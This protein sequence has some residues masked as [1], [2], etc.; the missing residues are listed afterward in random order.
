MAIS[1]GAPTRTAAPMAVGSNAND[2]GFNQ[3]SATLAEIVAQATGQKVLAPIN[4]SEFVSVATTALKTGYDPILGAIS[5]VISRTLFS[6]RPY[7]SKFRGLQA[8][9]IRY[10]NHVRKLSPVQNAPRDDDSMKPCGEGNYDQ[11][12]GCCPGVLQ[13]NFYGVNSYSRCLKIFR[14]Q[15]NSA[16]SGPDEFARFISMLM[17]NVSSM[18]EL[19][20]EATSRYV[21]ANL[22][23]GKIAGDTKNVRHLITE[24][25][26]LMGTN[27]T[28]DTIFA[29]EVFQNFARWLYATINTISGKLS[30]ETLEYHINVTGKPVL[31]HTPKQMQKIY[32]NAAFLNLVDTMVHTVNFDNSFMKLSDYETVD[33]WQSIGSDRS[34]NITPTYMLSDGSLTT[35]DVA[36]VNN[37]V[38]GV[39]FDEEAAGYTVVNEW[40]APTPFNARG[41]F[42]VMWWHYSHRYWNDFTENAVVL[43]LD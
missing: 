43:L 19:D 41:G 31:R 9:S 29:P 24:Y 7:Y 11:Y 3:L 16:F 2:M 5:Q 26:T 34:I 10:G 12:E 22:I 15:L 21:V 42:S 8:D 27:Y 28:S 37:N 25:N 32:L 17:T 13:T 36:V 20:K 40:S 23:G 4:T 30:N 38:L 33:F 35:P 6:I 18:I 14:D 39:I 1:N